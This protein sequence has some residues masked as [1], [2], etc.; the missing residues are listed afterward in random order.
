MS[1]FSGFSAAQY[2]SAYEPARA[3]PTGAVGT[4]KKSDLQVSHWSIAPANSADSSS[5]S[6]SSQHQ[7]QQQQQQHYYRPSSAP[8]SRP[9]DPHASSSSAA[10]TAVSSEPPRLAPG[11]GY[12][13][14]HDF[15]FPYIAPREVRFAQKPL[16]QMSTAEKAALAVPIPIEPSNHNHFDPWELPQALPYTVAKAYAQGLYPPGR[17]PVASTAGGATA[18]PR[19]LV[20]ARPGAAELKQLQ[21]QQ[22]SQSQRHMKAA[23]DVDVP[24]EFGA[25]TGRHVPMPRSGCGYPAARPRTAAADDAY[26]AR[27]T[28]QNMDE[29]IA[30]AEKSK[31]LHKT[32]ALAVTRLW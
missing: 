9:A 18:L 26:W 7:Q 11:L 22:Q 31:G 27:Y 14:R 5:S 13:P 6:A 21:Q 15:Y 23:S 20:P 25:R 16:S 8:A 24:T 10:A 29:I 3:G 1:G 17:A 4:L 28:P 30:R 12:G 2:A 32:S 19:R